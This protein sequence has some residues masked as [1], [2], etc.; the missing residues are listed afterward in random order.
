[1]NCQSISSQ[2]LYLFALRAVGTERGSFDDYQVLIDD[3]ADGEPHIVKAITL[4]S[5]YHPWQKD[6]RVNRR[7]TLFVDTQLWPQD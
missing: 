7:K 4:R 1:V 5:L 3:G 2:S 6:G